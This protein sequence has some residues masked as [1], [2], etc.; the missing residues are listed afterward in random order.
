MLVK[1]LD[2]VL[3]DDQRTRVLVEHVREVAFSLRT[4]VNGGKH[5]NPVLGGN[6]EEFVENQLP[7]GLGSINVASPEMG[8]RVVGEDYS[9]AQSLAQNSADLLHSIFNH[10]DHEGIEVLEAVVVGAIRIIGANGNPSSAHNLLVLLRAKEVGG[11]HRIVR[12]LLKFSGHGLKLSPGR[13]T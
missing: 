10:T 13:R 7:Y 6:T 5:R 9:R 1:R 11:R 2:G 3:E 8:S 4:N 12:V